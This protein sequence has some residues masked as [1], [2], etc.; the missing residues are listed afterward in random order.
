MKA[1][2]I[3]AIGLVAAA[4]L[5]MHQHLLPRESAES[6]AAIRRRGHKLFAWPSSRPAWFRTAA[7]SPS[8]AAPRPT[9]M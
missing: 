2:R 1:S 7:S 3:T 6:H 5:W 9:S 8:P 4:G